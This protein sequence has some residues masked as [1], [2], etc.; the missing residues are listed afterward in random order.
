LRA[1]AS[2]YDY[3]VEYIKSGKADIKDLKSLKICLS[4]SE[5]LNP[6]TRE[7]MYRLTGIPIVEVYSDEEIGTLG[8]QRIN[9]TK[10]YLNHA[11]CKFEMLKLGSDEPAEF[12]ELARIV[13]TDLHNYAFPM[14]RYDTGDTAV[15]KEGDSDSNGWF[16]IEKLYGRRVDMVYD[17]NGDVVHPMNLGR[18]LKNFTTIRQWQFIQKG[19][20]DYTIKLDVTNDSE[21]KSIVEELKNIFGTDANINVERVDDIPVLTSGKRKPVMCEWKKDRM[22]I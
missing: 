11:D 8:Q 10:Y 12:G 9:D 15:F 6:V 13:I 20:S 4:I 19:R 2:W 3:L 5:G 22:K 21:I 7:E 17:V 18:T 14:I 1:Y 16:Y